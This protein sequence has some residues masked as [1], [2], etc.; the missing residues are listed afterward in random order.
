MVLPAVPTDAV[1]VFLLVLAAVVLFATEVVSPD[2]TAIVVIVALVVLQPWTGVGTTTAFVGFSNVATVTVA[3]MYIL[4][5][6]IHRTGIVRRLGGAISRFA[7]GSENRLRWTMLSLSG[8]LAGVVNNTPVVAVFIPM[9]LELADE[10][11]ISPSKLLLPL[12]Y[13]AMLGGTLTLVGTS[14]NLL[15]SSLSDRLVGR[16]FSMFEF[17]HLGVLVLVV[18]IAYLGTVGPRLLPERIRPT[19]DLLGEFNLKGHITRLYVRDTSPLVGR[20]I[21]DGFAAVAGVSDVDVLEVVRYDGRHAVPDPAFE[22]ESGDVVTIRGGRDAIRTA[23]S[24]LDLW[25][26]PWVRIDEIE[27]GL[28]AGT[29]TLV[30]VRLPET[31]SLVGE[32]VGDVDFRRAFDVTVL[33]VRR[34]ETTVVSEFSDVA[35]GAGDTLLLR[36][37][38]AHVD[39]IRETPD[40]SVTAV[41]TEGFLDR[42]AATETYREDKQWLAVATIAGVV[43]A[44]ALGVVSIGISALAGVVAL[45][46]GGVLEPDEA[47]DAVS[48]DV[49]FLLA[50]MIPLGIALERSGGAA[51][52]ADLVVAAAGAMPPVGV[53]ALFYLVTAVVT[54]L[55]SNNATVVLLLPVAVDVATQLGATV[56]SFVLAVTF[57]AS[58]SF[59]S[60]VGYQTNLMVYRPGGYRVVDYLRLGAPLQLLLAVTVT[61]GIWAFWGV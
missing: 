7:A 41:A 24:T 58:T 23:A 54:N 13:T 43:V 17:T 61:L 4:S 31:S 46:V 28:S 38:G 10:Y 8:G 30:E 22:V 47:Y 20:P 33:G 5:E 51:V 50:G 26:L 49:I 11:R 14:T 34:G 1:V 40:L 21:G 29:G 18:G 2:V 57:A 15:A 45:I 3:A 35:L 60:P 59:L 6:G 32:R 25:Y 42:T 56:F 48:W 39:A 9:V 53:I 55:V 37:A 52:I 19:I 16:P 36:A 44:A 12:S 27:P